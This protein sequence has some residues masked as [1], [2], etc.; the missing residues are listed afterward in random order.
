MPAGS[1]L[2]RHRDFMKLWAGQAVSRLGSQVS[3]LA[4]PLIAIT[5]VKASTFQVGVLA[6]VE[7][8]PF[9]V[10]GLPAGVWVDRLAKRPV[11][12][13]A[14]AGRLVALATIPLAHEIAAVTMLQL[15]VV[16]F[17]VGVLTVFFDVAYQSYLPVLVGGDEL[18]DG[19]G[20]LAVSESA[21]TVAGPSLAGALIDLVGAPLAIIADAASFGL[22]G[23]ALLLI[24]RPEPHSERE[25]DDDRR[26]MRAEIAEGLGYVLRHPLLRPIAFC[27]ASSNLCSSMATAVLTV[28]MVRSLGMSAGLIGLTLALGNVGFVVGALVAARVTRLLGVGRTTVA[29]MAVC[30]AGYLLLPLATRSAPMPW[31]VAGSFFFALGSPVYNINQVSLRQAITPMRLQ[32]RMNASMRFMVWGTLPIGSLIGGALGTKIGLR[33]TLAVAGVGGVLA[34]LWIALSPLPAVHRMPEAAAPADEDSGSGEELDRPAP[35]VG[36]VIGSVSGPTG[37]M[38]EAVLGLGVPD[39]GDVG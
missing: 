27:T 1:S 29:S 35:G 26:G 18:V 38:D 10:V 33:P 13:A 34:F 15:L 9:I 14:D 2:W 23:V 24:R 5:V 12:I 31:L 3:V 37:I 19:N 4:I 8:A 25:N 30:G 6:A 17:V 16:A 21:A 36:G 22:S 7:F 11:L 39:D 32:G 28:F 20:K